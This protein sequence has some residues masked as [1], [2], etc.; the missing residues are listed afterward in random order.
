MSNSSFITQAKHKFASLSRD[1][2]GNVLM[3]MGFSVIPLTLA[4]GMAIDYS[5]AA[6]LQTKMNA[7]A[8][9]AALAAV[10][11]PMMKQDN[12]VAK[13]AAINMFNAQVAALQGLEY[14]PGNL[15]VTITGN[16]GAAN[17]RTATVSY[18]AKSTNSFAG[19]IG[20]RVIDI[21]GT[22]EAAAAAAPN[23]D[24]YVLL[25]TS[26]SMMLPSTTVGLQSMVA[27]T[28]GCAF[29]CHQTD[30]SANAGHLIKKNNVYYNYY[31]IAKLNGVTLRTDVLHT[32][33]RDM[34][35][36]ANTVAT[37]N[38]ATYRMGLFSFDYTFRTVWPKESKSGYFLETSLP[39]LKSHVND[40]EVLSYCRNNQRVC[41]TNDN[42][43]ATNF[44]VAFTE[45]SKS[46]P[47]PGE[48]T[49]NSGDRPQAILFLLT[50]G[51]RDESSGGRKMG[52]IPEALCTAVKNR[53]I[54]IAVLYTEYLPESAS[55][56]WSINN[57][58]NPFLTPTDKISP[59][60]MNC[61]SS[62]L[63]YKVTTNSNVSAALTALFEKAV[64]TAH[65]T[66]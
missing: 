21:G 47:N 34:T 58:R 60:L 15:T 63:F 55:D 12:G 45:A 52:P 1:R 57:V 56:T 37:T 51:M 40:A 14:N 30:K 23:T 41:G 42:D 16:A 50:D 17:K 66:R 3:I 8:D 25:D 31:E 61:A 11:Q 49:N 26:P 53:G 28:G 46:I 62:G 29:A 19:V 59:A 24:L 10:T 20:M 36:T 32:A 35:D 5:Q 65:L 27:A 38:G 39:T 22:S 33:V 2:R 43:T 54:R 9:A 4:T 44:T 7:A 18:S 64:A 13:Q 6:R 48:G